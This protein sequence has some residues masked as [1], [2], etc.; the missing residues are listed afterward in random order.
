MNIRLL[1]LIL[2]IICPILLPAQEFDL[3]LSVA[4]SGNQTHV[5]R[6]TILLAP[7]YSYT[8]NGG[9][10]TAKIENP[11][12]NGSI[13]YNSITD[14]E[15]RSLNTSYLVG[16]TNGTINVNAMGGAS[17]TVPLD[18]PPGVNGLAPQLSLVYSSG[19]GSGLA[20]Y[21]WQLGGISVISRCGR[22]FY[23]DGTLSDIELNY[24]DRYTMDGQRLITTSGDYGR[25][26]TTYQTEN[27]VFTRVVSEYSLGNGP[28]KFY[29]QTKNGLKY[30]YGYD[31]DGR[32]KVE[33]YDE[34]I[35]WYV[36]EVSD[37][38]G[39]V[40]NYSYLRDNNMVY[41]GEITYGP[42]TITFYYKE[43]YDILTSFFK[44]KKIVQRLLLDRIEIKYNGNIIKKY[45][46]K[47]NSLNDTYNKYSLLN[48]IVE[49][50]I[51]DSR[52]NSMVFSYTT[53]ATVAMAQSIYDQNHAYVSYESKLV[54]GDYNG[55]GK[56][57]FLCIPIPGK[58][59]WSGV[60]V[61]YGD[62]NDHFNN[63]WSNSNINMDYDHIDDIRSIDL[64][65]DGI[66]DILIEYVLNDVSYFK[67]MI[68]YGTGM[69]EPGYFY[70]NAARNSMNGKKY[71]MYL[72][73]E[74][75][76]ESTGNDF[77]G[78]GIQDVFIHDQAGNW[79]IFSYGNSEGVLTYHVKNMLGT[80]TISN[81]GEYVFSDDFNGDGK[82]EIWSVESSGF[83]IF[84]LVGSS[85]VQIYSQTW[86][87]KDHHY[88]LGDFNG[89]GKTDIF[90]YGYKTYDW[91]QWQIKLSTGT[92]FETVYMAQK[93][94]NLKDDYVRLGDFNGDGNTDIMAS[95]KTNNYTY[96][97]I[98]RY[99]GTEFYT[100]TIPNYPVATHQYFLADYNGDGRTDFVCTDGESPWWR[101]YQLYKS[102]GT[103]AVLMEK[104]A[105][106]L[107]QLTKIQYEK[108]SQPASCYTKG[109]AA[110]FPVT[111]F[112]GPLS[113]VKRV[114]TENGNGGK[115]TV[116]YAYEGAKIHRQ[117]KGFLCYAKTTLI[118]RTAG[119]KT[120]TNSTYHNT[121]FYPQAVSVVNR[122]ISGANIETTTSAWAEI[123]LDA[124][125][126]RIFPY[127]SSATQN[128][129]LTGHSITTT[130]EYDT[131]GNPVT[132]TK[133]YN[134]QTSETT[135]NTYTNTISNTDWLLG[136]LSQ[137][138]TT[139]TRSEETPVTRTV[140]YTYFTDGILKP[141]FI[142]YYENTS[143]YYYR[144]HDYDSHGNLIQLYEYG[145]GVGGRQTKY[146]YE[147]NGIRVKTVT[148]PQGHTTTMNYDTYG[149]LASEVDYLGNT[150]AYT[151]DNLGRAESKTQPDG[152]ASTT[153]YH[154]GLTGGPAN[155]CYYV[156]TAGNDGSLSKTWYDKTLREIRKDVKGFFGSMICTSS[157]YNAKGQLYRVSD[158][159][160][161]GGNVVW[162]ETYTYD[163]YG[164]T[165]S[166]TRNTGRN[167]SYAYSGGTVTETTAGK[168]YSKTYGAD[169]LIVSATDN[170]GT[171]TYSY[172]ADGKIKAITAPGGIISSMEYDIAGN[173]TKISDPS[174][175]TITYT[176]NSFGQVRTMTNAR[177]QTT[178]YNYYVDGRPSGTVTPEGTISY[179]YNANKQLM[180]VS[181][182]GGFSRSMVYDSLERVVSITENI[183]GSAPLTTLYTY[184]NKGRLKTKTH[185]SGIKETLSYNNYGY[186]NSISVP[187]AGNVYEITGL[188]A[189]LQKTSA[190]YNTVLSASYGYD[191]YGF[192][193][194]SVVSIYDYVYFQKF[195]YS[196]DPCTGNLQWRKDLLKNLTES[197]TYDNL[198]RLTQV[199]GP[200]PLAMSYAAN[201]NL[202]E[203]TDV[204]SLVFSYNIPSKPYALGSVTSTTGAIPAVNQT[205]TYTSFQKT[206]TI[207]EDSTEALFVYDCDGERARMVIKQNG[208]IVLTRWYSGSSYIKEVTGTD[209]TQYTFLGGDA[210]NAPVLAVKRNGSITYYALLRDYLGSITQILNTAN[211]LVSEY[212]FDA[213]GRR[214]N[215][216]DWSYN[217]AG[218][219]PLMAGRGYTGH[220][221]LPWFN[222]INMNGRLYDPLVARFLSPDN[223]VQA[224]DFT[225][226]FN[227]YTYCLNNPLVYVDP[228]GEFIFIIPNISWSK[229]GGLSIG[230]SFVFGIP[231]GA[232]VQ[233]GGGYNFKSHDVYGYAGVTFAF[234]TIYTSISSQIGWSAGY[235]AGASI[236]SGFPVSSN[237]LTAG[238]NYNITHNSWSGNISAWEVSKKGWSFNPSVS[239]MVFPERTTNFVRGQGFRSNNSVLS[240]FVAAGNQ[241][242][243]LDYFGFE[244]NYVD[245]D[246]VSSFYF[247]KK[248][249][250][251][252]GIRYRRG[253]FE[254]FESLYSSFIKE[255]FHMQRY[256]QG[257]F[258]LGNSGV[259]SVDRWPE[260]RQGI[261]RQYKTQGLHRDRTN[262]L[263]S[264]GNAEG[265][266]NSYNLYG[267]YNPS[268]MYQPYA[269]HW[270][271]FIYKI[272]RLW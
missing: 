57:D 166:I 126:K 56:T 228:S 258:D 247:D 137:S 257:G 242:G 199:N 135:A 211:Y 171:I 102:P 152:Y 174:A 263:K 226:N 167:T 121:F 59:T 252:Y 98:S 22:N 237:F 55:D 224:P 3:V 83:R 71:R 200:S 32:Q 10:M 46:L 198:D 17:Y 118:N 108:M 37:L 255:S 47:Y 101:G 44:G 189:R 195:Q 87:T 149:R 69:L 88:R 142:K 127:V 15:N 151:Y 103:T 182:P 130:F 65:A 253:S 116:D 163:T 29:A 219:P 49:Y 239:A 16:S 6:N 99:K 191:Q 165:L 272:P 50:G 111:D 213:W 63:V 185:P 147:T 230:I 208:N 78:D 1:I 136:R 75:D 82:A 157:E 187:N 245:E 66:D 209:T 64:N 161:A 235:T 221:E 105:T 128:N 9:S 40:I 120:E 23:N 20:G 251:K 150:T 271:H 139:Y 53:P 76:N 34:V 119:I 261:I 93:K 210:Y 81:L 36:T 5:A 77:N 234:N 74:K 31:E 62:G 60:R 148:D 117:G 122:L 70:N 158:P 26:N 106:S 175:G 124:A 25:E 243:A 91:T 61:C 170:G 207:S 18:L 160:Y 266:I 43:R 227:R 233:F 12:V 107:N 27:D 260:E 115:D 205:I 58:A 196:F 204:S 14:P 143:Y 114:I 145:T 67:E 192:P 94:A 259:F 212:S 45:E 79:I 194:S 2:A 104:T 265:M 201:G 162:A 190:K 95:C 262:F 33:G 240:R 134:N 206:K 19:S 109:S 222:L 132:I 244:G 84:S 21:G 268:Y 86:L 225:Q 110:A 54:A 154:W 229:K 89:D 164:R 214:R 80:G 216:S 269:N 131:Y 169:G 267:D 52:L 220:E 11:V 238:A 179:T 8:P 186:L 155:A 250:S 41:P 92:D 197:F 7:G 202:M 141:D 125:R 254:S 172:Y 85:L 180:A 48:E 270:W 100:E 178:T 264:I 246:G 203:K 156:Q 218:Q 184:D 168:T 42:N 140:S 72:L 173:R 39:N 51:N 38:Y 30:L 97:Y 249:P 159:Y 123:V 129:S 35:S 183:P 24:N 146:T 181:S 133:T 217:L 96:F 73:Q 236:F 68:S 232:S 248:D 177:G 28:Q 241:Q 215:P 112:Q 193:S 144:N 13:A 223:Y 113:V 231:S 153:T 176:Y 256:E 188:N 138:V 90:L 4:E